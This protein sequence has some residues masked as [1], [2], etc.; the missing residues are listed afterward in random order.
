MAILIIL[1]S[2]FFSRIPTLKGKI[3]GAYTLS[4]K[5]ILNWKLPD[6][7]LQDMKLS[8]SIPKAVLDSSES[9]SDCST[10][11]DFSQDGEGSIWSAYSSEQEDSEITGHPHLIDPSVGRSRGSKRSA[12]FENNEPKKIRK[13]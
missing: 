8:L 4:E 13:S 10:F 3:R 9:E 2:L 12:T 11:S 5:V 6:V 7:Q 1:F